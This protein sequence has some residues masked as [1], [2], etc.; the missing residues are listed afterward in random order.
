[1]TD[2]N[3]PFDRDQNREPRNALLGVTASDTL[4]H[5]ELALG[6]LEAIRPDEISV[7]DD[8]GLGQALLLRTVRDAVQHARLT[9][10]G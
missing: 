7:N 8:E 1:M 2:M 10:A 9:L 3:I 5:A 4:R 6:T